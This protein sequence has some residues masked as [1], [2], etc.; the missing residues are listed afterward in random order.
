MN[1]QE[2]Y[3]RVLREAAQR[4]GGEAELAALAGV[5][6]EQISRWSAGGEI[7]P[8]EVFLAGLDA[9]AYGR[10][11]RKRVRRVVVIPTTGDL[12]QT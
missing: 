3:S 8:L 2:R 6:P 1:R 4:L 12:S 10:A 7:A 11:A 9:I 5:S